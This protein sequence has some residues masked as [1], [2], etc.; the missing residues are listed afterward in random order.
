MYIITKLIEIKESFVFTFYVLNKPSCQSNTF[1]K[2][3]IS[4]RK[5]IT[6]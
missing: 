1:V 4:K 6:T 5:L 3:A 2:K